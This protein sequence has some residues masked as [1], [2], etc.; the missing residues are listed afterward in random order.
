[1][2]IILALLMFLTIVPI[3]RSQETVINNTGG[4]G[5]F[6]FK[7]KMQ[8]QL[9]DV[10]QQLQSLEH[11]LPAYSP[12]KQKA[13]QEALVQL[14]HLRDTITERLDALSQVK[15]EQY[16][17]TKQVIEHNYHRLCYQLDKIAQK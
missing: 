17:D 12:T 7:Q 3:A 2:K 13:L 4:P 6:Q 16:A 10:S 15:P 14:Q 9:A 1:M 8:Q 11:Q 5:Y